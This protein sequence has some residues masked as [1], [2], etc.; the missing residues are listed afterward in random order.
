VTLPIGTNIAF[1]ISVNFIPTNAIK[2]S[3]LDIEQ[4]EGLCG[5]ISKTKDTSDD[6]K[7]MGSDS[8]TSSNDFATSWRY[9]ES[10]IVIVDLI[11][12]VLNGMGLNRIEGKTNMLD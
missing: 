8:A 6:Y 1:R 11:L 3:V 5:Y 9:I 7:P 4:T 10:Y 12:R 2:P